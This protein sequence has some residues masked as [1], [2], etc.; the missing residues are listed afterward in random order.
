[1]PLQWHNQIWQSLEEG[2]GKR[3]SE[4]VSVV[5]DR[6]VIAVGEAER[7]GTGKA[8]EG[9][10][11]PPSPPLSLPSCFVYRSV[12]FNIFHMLCL[13]CQRPKLNSAF[14]QE[15]VVRAQ[16]VCESRGGRPGLLSLISPTVSV[17]AKQHFIHT[18]LV[19]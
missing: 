8:T 17:D 12:Q 1:M 15:V 6:N 13:L 11:T 19:G 18:E 16:E 7:K 5:V 4:R 3:S 14:Q 2:A 10:V 9:F